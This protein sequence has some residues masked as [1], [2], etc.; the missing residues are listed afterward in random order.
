MQTALLQPSK[1]VSQ[2]VSTSSTAILAQMLPVEKDSEIISDFHIGHAWMAAG[3]SAPPSRPC[4][5]A[6]WAR[7]AACAVPT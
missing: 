3:A 7:P 1:R 5:A 2:S 6:P 4:R